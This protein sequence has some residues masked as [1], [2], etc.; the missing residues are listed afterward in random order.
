M[1]RS[2]LLLSLAL[3]LAGCGGTDANDA[4]SHEPPPVKD[5]V[6]GPLVGT[7]DKARGVQD[8]VMKQKEENDKAIE[9]NEKAAVDE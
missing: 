2:L 3:T 7:M 5:T 9:R 8:T 4:R 1:K 6:F